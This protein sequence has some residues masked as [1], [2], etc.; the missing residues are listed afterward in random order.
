MT[1]HLLDIKDLK[2][3]SS[4]QSRGR[5]ALRSGWWASSSRAR[6]PLLHSERQKTAEP[7]HVCAE[8]KRC[9]SCEV[10]HDEAGQCENGGCL[11]H[12]QSAFQ[13]LSV[14]VSSL[15]GQVGALG[16]LSGS[17]SL[18]ELLAN[19]SLS[20]VISLGGFFTACFQI[21]VFKGSIYFVSC[22]MILI[23]H[24]RFLNTFVREGSALYLE[25]LL[26]IYLRFSLFFF[27]WA[28]ISLSVF[29]WSI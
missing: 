24:G 16:A 12:L 3:Y 27:K 7:S 14:L 13:G 26:L 10:E 9:C 25:I 11:C 21:P 28:S 19:L 2:R 17:R 23:V 5:G 1:W 8:A 6:T 29:Y 4:L 18:T 20:F 22:F 15:H